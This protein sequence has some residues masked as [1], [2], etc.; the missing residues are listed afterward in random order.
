MSMM[1]KINIA[2]LVSGLAAL[3]W[4]LSRLIPAFLESGVDAAW[5]WPMAASLIAFVV[6]LVVA[7]V[8]IAVRDEDIRDEEAR[9]DDERDHRAERRGD[10]WAGHVL[11]AFVFFALALIVFDQHA[12][13]VANT[14]YAGVMLAGTVGL[15]VRLTGGPTHG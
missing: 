11:Q 2:A 3:G 12:F 15:L 5:K 4:Y 13:W 14:L 1:Q 7:S 10:A 9:I 8:I 6:L